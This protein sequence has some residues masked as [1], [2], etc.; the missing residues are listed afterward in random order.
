M[1][2]EQIN[3]TLSECRGEIGDWKDWSLE[4]ISNAFQKKDNVYKI[5]L[6]NHT[7]WVFKIEHTIYVL[8]TQILLL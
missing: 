5:S 1:L 4:P 8:P 2:I 6:S 3:R 7:S